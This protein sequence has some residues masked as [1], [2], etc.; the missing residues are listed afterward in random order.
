MCEVHRH[1]IYF[2]SF[3]CSETVLAPGGK[4]DGHIQT[5]SNLASS[6]NLIF[7]TTQTLHRTFY[8][9]QSLCRASTCLAFSTTVL[10]LNHGSQ[11]QDYEYTVKQSAGLALIFTWLL[12][13]EETAK[14]IS[15]VSFKWCLLFTRV[16]MMG[17][18]FVMGEGR[19]RR[20]AFYKNCR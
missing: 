18:G 20:F 14:I 1:Q 9:P 11:K 13:S 19:E 7:N 15:N 5:P 2:G 8:T 6:P 10:T 3:F 17:S 12:S 4:D 16:V